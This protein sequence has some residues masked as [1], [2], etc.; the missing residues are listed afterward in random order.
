LED[1]NILYTVIEEFHDVIPAG[2][3]MNTYPSVDE[4]ISPNR[5]IDVYVSAGPEK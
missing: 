3:V 5:I 4:V 1:N 2:Y